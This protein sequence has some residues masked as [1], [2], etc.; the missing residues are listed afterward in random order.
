MHSYEAR[1][2]TRGHENLNTR[3]AMLGYIYIYSITT[4]FYK[5]IV[6]RY[7]PYTFK[8][9]FINNKGF[10]GLSLEVTFT[11]PIFSPSN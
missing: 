1:T 2:R 5:L 3:I 4:H 9:A 6:L 10:K 8:P 11:M 7:Y